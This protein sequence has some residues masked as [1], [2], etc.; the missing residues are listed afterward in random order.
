MLSQEQAND[1]S[2]ELV[3]RGWWITQAEPTARGLIIG[4]DFMPRVRPNWLKAFEV[5]PQDA[6]PEGVE[7]I[8]EAWRGDVLRR[9]DACELSQTVRRLL[10]EHGAEAVRL[11]MTG[12]A[13]EHAT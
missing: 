8:V 12:K 2:R 10:D 6:S 5:G 1:L 9:L 13:F 11:A 7:R 4:F 3:R